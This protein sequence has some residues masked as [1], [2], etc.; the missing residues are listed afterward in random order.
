[1][2]LFQQSLP[3]LSA[4][5]FSDNTHG[6]VLLSCQ[7]F[8]NVSRIRSTKALIAVLPGA[9]NDDLRTLGLEDSS[10]STHTHTHTPAF[11]S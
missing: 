4:T 6:L 8:A 2:S 5:E 10:I 7:L 11:H 9:K 3:V 1:M